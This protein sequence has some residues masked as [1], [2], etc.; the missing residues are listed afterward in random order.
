M[1]K[2]VKLDIPTSND[3]MTSQLI[4][5]ADPSF[6]YMAQL[7]KKKN[8]FGYGSTGSFNAFG[9]NMALSQRGKMRV[10]GIRPNPR[11]GHTGIMSEGNLIVFGGDRHHMPFND[12]F[13][14]DLESEIDRQSFLFVPERPEDD[15]NQMSQQDLNRPV[16]IENQ[17]GAAQ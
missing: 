17:P 1:G 6:E 15:S 8:A 11:D 13:V 3:M 16:E 9:L 4:A 14:L 10:N 7:K 2:E 12:M 5:A